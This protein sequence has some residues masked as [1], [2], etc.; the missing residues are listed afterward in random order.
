MSDDSSQKAEK[1]KEVINSLGYLYVNLYQVLSIDFASGLFSHLGFF[2]HLSSSSFY[3][4]CISIFFPIFPAFSFL[5]QDRA[6]T[7]EYSCGY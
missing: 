5:I 7:R 4:P 2:S 1:A 3:Y 6:F